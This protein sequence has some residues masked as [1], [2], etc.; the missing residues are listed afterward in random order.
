MLRDPFRF[1]QVPPPAPTY[2]G[3]TLPTVDVR[4]SYPNDYVANAVRRGG[5]R[6]LGTTLGFMGQPQRDMVELFTGVEQTPSEALGIT[7]PVGSFLTDAFIDPLNVGVTSLGGLMM[8]NSMRNPLMALGRKQLRPNINDVI[9]GGLSQLDD[10]AGGVP[11][12]EVL[13]FIAGY[14]KMLSDAGAV[15]PSSTRSLAERLSRK[16]NNSRYNREKILQ[17][18]P[19]EQGQAKPKG[20]STEDFESMKRTVEV[21]IKGKFS[22]VKLDAND[23]PI[24]NVEPVRMSTP[25]INFV[26]DPNVDNIM[27]SRNPKLA[28]ELLSRFGKSSINSYFDNNPSKAIYYSNNPLTDIGLSPNLSSPFQRVG[29]GNKY[30]RVLRA[31]DGTSDFLVKT[32]QGFADGIY[33]KDKSA[34]NLRDLSQSMFHELGH[35]RASRLQPTKEEIKV[36]A[37]AWDKILIGS[38]GRKYGSSYRG[39]AELESHQAQLRAYLNDFNG[40]RV[41]T[42]KDIPEIKKAVASIV[43]SGQI[44]ADSGYAGRWYGKSGSKEFDEEINW[45]GLVNALNKIGFAGFAGATLAPSISDYYNSRNPNADLSIGSAYNPRR[46]Q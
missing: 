33:V 39:G 19:Y 35:A 1:Y 30:G 36:L 18:R 4:S 15:D 2:F 8:R 6:F 38:N 11:R 13:D 20:V 9:P 12:E 44:D 5:S 16:F 32:N 24:F 43:D 41:Y 40:E 37:N 46:I 34:V 14:E 28:D 10:A 21:P 3:G 17:F 25:P 27:I 23:K 45:K 31:D 29:P 22:D 26:S 42:D 7:N